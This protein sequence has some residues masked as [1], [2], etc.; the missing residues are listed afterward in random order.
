MTINIERLKKSKILIICQENPF[1]EIYSKKFIS[2]FEKSN[3]LEKMGKHENL[4]F[5]L[6]NYAKIQQNR[7]TLVCEYWRRMFGKKSWVFLLQS[8]IHLIFIC[9]ILRSFGLILKFTWFFNKVL[10]NACCKKRKIEQLQAFKTRLGM[11]EIISNY[12]LAQSLV[13]IWK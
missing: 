10:S 3:V 7:P 2:K 11:W 5:Y 12:M 1:R 9:N 6:I 13:L 4:G 8:I